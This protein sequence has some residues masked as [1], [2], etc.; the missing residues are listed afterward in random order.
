MVLIKSI[1]KEYD[2]S[3]QASTFG[4]V[5][6]GVEINF[7]KECVYLRKSNTEPISRIYAGSISQDI[8]DQLAI[9]FIDKIKNCI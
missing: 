3:Y 1:T 6:N 8:A 5:K 9:G 2:G 7:E 4:E